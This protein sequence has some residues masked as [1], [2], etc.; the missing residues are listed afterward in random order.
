M[1]NIDISKLPPELQRAL[2]EQAQKSGQQPTS[3]GAS[4]NS[5]DSTDMQA[6]QGLP[7]N[8]APGM[9]LD[10][11]SAPTLQAQPGDKMH[12]AQAIDMMKQMFAAKATGPSLEQMPNGG[13]GSQERG[14]MFA[15][16]GQTRPKGVTSANFLDTLRSQVGDAAA[17][18]MLPSGLPR[19]PDGTPFLSDE[20]YKTII[21]SRQLPSGN[22][23][24]LDKNTA[25]TLGIVTPEQA[26][27]LYKSDTDTMALNELRLGVLASTANTRRGALS[28]ATNKFEA[29]QIKELTNS[30]ADA[31]ATNA[32]PLGQQ[33][34]RL[35]AII[36]GR[37][38]LQGAYD[39][40]SGEY[41]VPPAM[42]KEL[43][44]NL[45]RAVSGSGQLSE[46]TQEELSSPTLYGNLAG[47]FQKITGMPVTGNTQDVLK[48]YRDQLDR[49]GAVSQDLFN[50]HAARELPK[51]IVLQKTNPLAYAATLQQAFGTHDYRAFVGS[52][53]DGEVSSVPAQMNLGGRGG[54]MPP[55]PNAAPAPVAMP[56]PTAAP[57]PA[58]APAAKK[59]AAAK[60]A[61]RH[62]PGLVIH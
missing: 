12:P 56:A 39:Q 20:M 16:F 9:P 61:A 45:A 52:G 32:T 7:A 3:G 57:A 10:D 5:G 55:N 2:F 6:Q 25:V 11:Q 59:E 28:L 30:I 26:N 1:A 60:P 21:A 4:I 22:N 14:G 13:L 23:P 50:A 53:P 38:I 19:T 54:Q 24:Q 15:A 35:D 40:A 58:S 36:H 31:K 8:Y 37:Q 51:G 48:M 49:Q 17:A 34:N 47:A 42:Y 44:M 33:A 27:K 43:V 41:K 29:D 62:L 46:K 18:K